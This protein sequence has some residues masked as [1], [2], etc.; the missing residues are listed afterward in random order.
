M[1]GSTL[2]TGQSNGT[3]LAR[4]FDGT[5]FGAATTVPLNGLTSA[6]F[7]IANLTGMFFD[8]TTERLYYTVSGDTHMYYRYFEPEDNIIGAQTLTISGNGDGLT[9]NT[10]SEMTMANGK[11]YYVVTSGQG[12]NQQQNLWSINFAGGKP[13]PGTQVLVSGPAKG[14][15]QTWAGRGM[16]VLSS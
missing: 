10:A 8:P 14:D 4:T 3:F 12:A 2:Y 1:I 13:V 9:W 11:I 5:T 6:Q 16:F 15:G 7:P